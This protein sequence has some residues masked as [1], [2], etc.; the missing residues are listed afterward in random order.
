MAGRRLPLL[1]RTAVLVLVVALIAFIAGLQ[2][3]PVAQVAPAPVP[4]RV[5]S[6]PAPSATPVPTGTLVAP[7]SLLPLGVYHVTPAEATEIGLAAQF[8]AAY[9][10]GQLTTVMAI[11]STEPHLWDCNYVTRAE[12]RLSGRSVIEAYLKARFAEHDRW[13]VE[14]YQEDPAASREVVVLALR[15]SNDTLRRLGA[16]GGAKT[17][18]PEDFY[19]TFNPDRAHLDA[20]AWNTMPASVGTLCS[21]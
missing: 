4:S 19:L 9:N 5:S 8:Y 2:V 15:R 13:T 20:I 11:L 18:F 7:S 17:S 1:P 3:H 6:P 21:P 16:P 10:A 12:V 14:F